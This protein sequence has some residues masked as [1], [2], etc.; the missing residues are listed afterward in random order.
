MS[1]A[2]A[3]LHVHS[4]YSLLDGACKI[5]K[6]AARA[7]SFDQP[8]LALTDHGVMNGAV[9]LFTASRKHGIKPILGCE[10]YVVED[11]ARRG[12]GRLER[13]HLTLIA[14]T[15]T[16]YRN[17]VKL[18]SAGFL[19]GFQRGKPS[20]D[21]TQ[22]AAHAE[23]VIALTGCLQSRFCQH[24]LADDPARAR[25]HAQELM[26]VFGEDN[27]YF[28][29]QKNGLAAQDKV[30]EGVVRIARE[31]GRPLVGTGDVHYLRRE[32]YHHHAALLCVQ[33]KSTLSQPKISFDTNEFYLRS[34]EEMA[35]AFAQWPE[36]L[37]ST[38]EI[39]ERCDVELELGRQLIPRYP[40]PGGETEEAYVRTLVMEGLRHRY[41]DPP[42]AEAVARA[43][44]ELGVIERMGFCGYFLIVWDFV[45]HAKD[46]GIA[47]GPGRGSAA[48][49]IV[50]YCLQITDLDPLRY[51]LLFERF[52]NPER[53]SMPDIDIDF[54]VRGR[55]RVY[56]Y[57]TEKYGKESVAQI[58]TFGKMFPRAATRD[59]ARVL[60]HDYG[61]GDRLAKLIP[62]PIMGRPPSFEE[63]L[64]GGEPLRAE[65]DRDPTA[66]QIVE[67]AQGLEGIVRNS[68]IHAAAVV[69]ADRP[70]TD[71]VPLQIAEA[72]SDE[73]GDR[74]FRT[75]TQFSMKPVEQL[76][77]LKMDFLGLRNLDV[78]E[79]ALD[80]IER[81]TGERPDMANLP[82]DDA[83]T[84]E[85]MARGDSV[86]VFQF[87][88]E[89]MRETLKK[90][91]PSELEHLIA[92]NALYRPGP[93]EQIPTYT[94]GKHNPDTVSYP[95]E[96]LRP[97]LQP[98][99][100]VCVYQ[101]QAMQIA[102]EI[103]GFSG[104]KADD[105]RKAI[106]KKNREAMAKLK[107]EFFAGCR[108]SGTSEAV[109][110]QLWTTNER[111]ADYS[112]NKSHS[113]CYALIAY[114][115]AWLKANYPAEYMAALISSVMDTKDKVPF[116]VAQ[117]EQMR[118]AILPPDV[119]L[120][121]HEFV[122]VDGN[123]RFGLDAVKGV[124]YQA[125]EAIKQARSGGGPFTSL[126]DFCARVDGR[127]VNKKA[128][129]ALIKCGAFGSTGASRKG[130]L[131][132]LEQA[133]GAGQKAQQDALIGQSS[134]FDLGPA[135]D[136]AGSAVAAFA[137]PSHAPVP[138]GE[139]ERGELLAAEKEAIGLFISAHPLKDVGAALRAKVDCPLSEVAA[140]RDGDWVT[141]GG[142]IAQPKRIRTKKGDPMMFATLDD[143]GAAVEIVVFGKAMAANEEALE[144]DS[145][146]L[147]RGRVDHKDRDKTCVIAQQVERFDPTPQEVQRA[148]L[149][150]AKASLAPS[151]LRLRL[152]PSGLPASILAELKELLGSFPGECD[153]VI[154]LRTAAGPRRLRLGSGFRV[155]RSASL[156]AELDSLLGQAF[157]G[158]AEPASAPR[159]PAPPI[160]AAVGAAL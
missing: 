94:R 28:E 66:R 142:M 31:L 85:M 19:D 4:E 46:S 89:G 129:E 9:E 82:L 30:N 126:Y 146:V 156:H 84:Y 130:M 97:I 113:A 41:G 20:V 108:A 2:C 125:V 15:P 61:A 99:N 34:S 147:V 60:G 79:D 37:A 92:L 155:T 16:G 111:S 123:I 55:D 122:V 75:V 39:A 23:G 7:A 80:I 49:S 54:S 53:V 5:D 43:E 124:G 40:T 98:T 14:A 102:K 11:H 103:A 139:F 107:P 101:E 63:C 154:E 24:L 32:D 1:S 25:G 118:I 93:M 36:A 72:G 141:V 95:D 42:P 100:G 12:P 134:I 131:A 120:S 136:G 58:V 104:A 158:S 105:L 17:L 119:N 151:A 135:T 51:D 137:T 150:A 91:R 159:E 117:A 86:G 45:K 149:Q 88:S 115:T 96:R 144:T 83:K 3:H 38:M 148:E 78:I 121:D 109:T 56:R 77:L 44:Y 106:G 22:M 157:L 116:F 29:V 133:Q 68:S 57:V 64:R 90:V 128:I 6:L 67:V 18:S 27:V 69:I 112:F 71:I 21:L 74:V 127:C 26:N 10:A 33:T 13:F 59:A 81:S 140:R 35:Q 138:P 76:G 8:A 48:G 70:L 160:A 50:A 52:L 132:V 114:R 87:E 143:L 65:V 110:E 73:N 145:I 47:V 62:D 153:V 152:D